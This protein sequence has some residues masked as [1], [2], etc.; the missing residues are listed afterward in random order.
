MPLPLGLAAT[1]LALG[2][3]GIGGSM[4]TNES[5]RKEAERNRRFQERMSSTAAQRAV[6]DYELA[7]LNPALAYEK[8]ASSPGGS[9]ATMSDSVGAGISTALQAKMAAAQMRNLEAQYAKTRFEGRSAE[10]DALLKQNT[11]QER[12]LTTIAEQ[13]FLRAMMPL[14]LSIRESDKAQANY[15]LPSSF[16]EAWLDRAKSLLRL[17]DESGVK[18]LK[19]GRGPA[20]KFEEALPS[21]P[22][23]S[24]MTPFRPRP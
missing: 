8:P 14:N 18:M 2:A 19:A 10:L 7:G 13:R 15:R 4:M 5:N 16:G 11:Q 17:G 1:D 20:M 9:T 3:L 24:G 12:E 23:P 21:K 6:R 22:P